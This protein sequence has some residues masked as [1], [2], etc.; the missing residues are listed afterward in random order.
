MRLPIKTALAVADIIA[1]RKA[2]RL[3]LMCKYTVVFRS[4]YE[5]I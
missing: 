1:P 3:V 2:G 5:F 4:L